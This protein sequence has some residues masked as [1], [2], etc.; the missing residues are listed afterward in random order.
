VNAVFGNRLRFIE[1]ISLRPERFG[2]ILAAL[3]NDVK[4]ELDLARKLLGETHD[5][6]P[7]GI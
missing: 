7:K 5:R 3:A 2:Q 6:N 4:V 1:Q